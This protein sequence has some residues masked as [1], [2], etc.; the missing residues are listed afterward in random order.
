[1]RFSYRSMIILLVVGMAVLYAQGPRGNHSPSQPAQGQALLDMSKQVTITGA[2]SAVNIAFGAQYP[3]IEVNKTLIKVAPVWFL[4]ENDFEIVVADQVQVI[5]APSALSTDPY[6]Y[7]IQI[8]NTGTSAQITLRSSSGTPLWTVR[9]AKEQGKEFGLRS[10]R[11]KANASGSGTCLDPA[12]ITVIS[13]VVESVNMGVG[14]QQ[15]A[16]VIKL[17]DGSLVS[18]KIG[19]ERILLEN[20]FELS[21][22][23]DVTAKVAIVTCKN[24]VVALEL[25]NADGITLVL[26][27]EDGTPAWQ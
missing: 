2:V 26:R 25:T 22:G 11:Q 7:A 27:S 6:M 5:A 4:L 9:G 18:V 14:I 17:A 8:V 23:E 1:M 19:P 21:P 16:L 12:S 24:E 15:P 10:Q 3:S 20:E 13:G